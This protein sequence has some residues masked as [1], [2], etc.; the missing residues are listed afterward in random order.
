MKEEGF[1]YSIHKEN[2]KI[3]LITDALV[4]L[5]LI[6]ASIFIIIKIFIP[7]ISENSMFIFSVVFT[8]IPV[9]LLLIFMW[10]RLAPWKRPFRARWNNQ[11]IVF[12][13]HKGKQNSFHWKE[14]KD[15]RIEG[16]GKLDFLK[17]ITPLTF[18]DK[19]SWNAIFWCL[20]SGRFWINPKLVFFHFTLKNNKH[21]MIPVPENKAKEIKKYL[22]KISSKHGKEDLKVKSFSLPKIRKVIWVS[23]V[24]AFFASLLLQILK[25]IDSSNDLF[26]WFIGIFVGIMFLMTILFVLYMAYHS[27]RYRQVILKGFVMKGR[28]ALMAGFVYLLFA[29]ILLYLVGIVAYALFFG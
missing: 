10:M 3:S 5:I 27:F 4:P 19:F 8:A 9:V 7:K 29:G 23:I 14:I 26:L 18:I 22:E 28:L 25:F 20:K 1:K 13:S 24:I 17:R 2:S 6:I 12:E 21:F 11:G 15:I 16:S